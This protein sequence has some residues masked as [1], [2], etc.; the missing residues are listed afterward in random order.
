MS[1]EFTTKR[2]SMGQIGEE[3][4]PALMELLTNDI[5]KQTY[6]VPDFASE[7]E[8]EASACQ[9]EA[10]AGLVPSSERSTG[11]VH[12]NPFQYSCQENPMDRGA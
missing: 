6:M 7:A 3:D 11:G 8:V 4:L 9:G 10:D 5:V 1:M 12:G 2:L